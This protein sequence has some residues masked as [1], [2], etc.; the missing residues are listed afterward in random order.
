MN[1]EDP[2]S[3]FDSNVRAEA[4]RKEAAESDFPP[5]TT[6][7]NAHAHTFYSFNYKGYSP[8]RFALEAK[9]AGLEMGGIVD[10]DV[11]DGLDEFWQASRLLD[12]KACV[13]IESRVFVP[14]FSDRVIN[15]PGEPGISYHMGTGFTTTDIPTEAQT[16][17]DGMRQTSEQRNRAMVER[18]NAFLS[19]LELNYEQDVMPLVPKGNAT[20]RHLCLAYARK[21]A[22]QYSEESALRNFWS[23]KLG[24]AAEDLKDVPDGRG[25][26]DLIRAKTMKQGGAGYVQPDSGSFPKMAEMNE[27]VLQCGALPTMTWLDGCSAGEE[28]IEELLEVARSTGVA[29]FNIIPDR[30]YTPG[31]KDQK[32]ANLQKVVEICKDLN[33]PLLGGTEMN[34]PGQKFVDDFDSEELKPIHPYFLEGSRILHAHST[35]Q[36]LAGMGYLSPWAENQFASVSAKNE[37]YT[38]FGEIFSPRGDEALQNDLS[39][40][41]G[42]GEVISLAERVMTA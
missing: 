27:F 33:M 32:L 34:S 25:M 22:S 15:S 21:A 37:F 12:L 40:S 31:T 18:V 17:L 20:E 10:F 19:P 35:L 5:P 28:A 8:S 26:T 24:V 6:W 16:F 39:D 23:E 29:V 2:C 9:R 4:L 41:L 1:S 13:G 38:R 3:H 14:E 42:S 7:V 30:N 36:R 11:L